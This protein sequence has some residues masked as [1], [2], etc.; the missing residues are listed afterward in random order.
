MS[1]SAQMLQTLYRPIPNGSKS[2][3][4]YL[5]M[6]SPCLS[7]LNLS[8]LRCVVNV[9]ATMRVSML[10]NAQN[11]ELL[12]LKPVDVPDGRGS[13]ENQIQVMHSGRSCDRRGNRRPVLPSARDRKGGG[14]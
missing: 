4:S 12:K 2:S 6:P 11:L 9:M 3:A 10:W 5:R 13:L 8:L 14:P 7:V 1:R